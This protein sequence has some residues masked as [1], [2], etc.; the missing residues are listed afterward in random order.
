ME[1]DR[2]QGLTKISSLLQILQDIDTGTLLIMRI[3]NPS[4]TFQLLPKI[5]M[6]V[7]LEQTRKVCTS[8]TACNK[9]ELWSIPPCWNPTSG[10]ESWRC[11]LAGL[12]CHPWRPCWWPPILR[13]VGPSAPPLPPSACVNFSAW[14]RTLRIKCLVTVYHIEIVMIQARTFAGHK[15]VFFFLSSVVLDNKR[16]PRHSILSGFLRHCTWIIPYRSQLVIKLHKCHT[17]ASIFTPTAS[18]FAFNPPIAWC[19]TQALS[20]TRPAPRARPVPR[21]GLPERAALMPSDAEQKTL[22]RTSSAILKWKAGLRWHQNMTTRGPET[23]S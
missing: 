4:L 14:R 6:Q 5:P 23:Y 21:L 19:T 18:T 3:L 2:T 11:C 8:C 12:S 17:L 15:L 13:W 16:A 9:F 1:F 10:K 20:P 22:R 7:G